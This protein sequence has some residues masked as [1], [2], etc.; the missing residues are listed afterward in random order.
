[1]TQQIRSR[2][3]Q[4]RRGEIP[5]GYKKTEVGIVPV[6]WDEIKLSDVLKK[7]KNKNNDNKIHNILTNSATQ[8]IVNQID[9]FEKQIANDDNTSNYYLVF[10]GCF[11]YNPRISTS[12]PCGP[13]N[14]YSGQEPGIMSPLYDVYV[15]VGKSQSYSDFLSLYFSSSKWHSYMNNIANYGARSDRMNVTSEAMNK[16]PLPLPPLPEQKKIA[17]ILET[18]DRVIELCEKKIEQLKKLKNVFLQ[19]MFPKPGSTVPE[20][21][22]PEFKEDWEQRK[23]NEIYEKN[24][25]RNEG[26]FSWDKTISISSMTFNENGN[27]ASDESLASYKVL[28]IGDVAFEGH[29]SKEYRYG[30]FVLNDLENG[31]MS[32]RF[33]T[34]RPIVDQDYDFWKYYIHDERVMRSKLVNSTKA[35][36]MMNELVIDD[37]F[38]QDILVPAIDEQR[39]I[40]LA[41]RNIDNLITLHQ[42]KCDEEKQKKKALMQ[43]LL[44]GI[45]RVKV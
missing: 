45:V 11:V 35:G 44:T 4:I 1:M 33:T 9:Y 3:E 29:T 14:R 38:K 28:R 25:E 20:W 42:R 30:R 13:F 32:P 8:G 16:M 17:E 40:G 22:F 10:N 39:K 37:L 41:L 19:K 31:I 24:D 23:F 27:G 36:T 5:N 34:L 6:E 7:Q 15:F 12:A 2:I 18:Q 26:Q 43:L 21:R